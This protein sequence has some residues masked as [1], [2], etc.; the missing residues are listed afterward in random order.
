MNFGPGSISGPG[1]LNLGGRLN[2]TSG[3]IGGTGSMTIGS[4]G[5]L[6]VNAPA[7]FGSVTLSRPLFN[8]GVINLNSGTLQSG[9]TTIIN[10]IDGVLNIGPN[11]T[12][13]SFTGTS[14][15]PF[16]NY[17][18]IRLIGSDSTAA[19]LPQRFTS[20]GTIAA[21]SGLTQFNVGTWGQVSLLAGSV[22][23]GSSTIDIGR[24]V[25][26]QGDV[27][28]AGTNMLMGAAP[29][30]WSSA[31]VGPGSAR[32]TGVLTWTSGGFFGTLSGSTGPAGRLIVESGGRVEITNASLGRE[33][34]NFGIVNFNSGTMQ[35]GSSAFNNHIS[36]V[37]NVRSPTSFVGSAS[38]LLSN[39]G[40]MNLSAASISIS[41][42]LENFGVLNIDSTLLPEPI[43]LARF[44][45]GGV[46]NGQLNTG[47]QTV[48][49]QTGASGGALH[50]S[51]TT[52]VAAGVSASIERLRQGTLAI[53]SGARLTLAPDGGPAGTSIVRTLNLVSPSSRLDLADNHFVVDYVSGDNPYTSLRGAV[54]AAQIFSSSAD[55]HRRVGLA[56]N[57]A[58]NLPIFGGQLVDAS[59][60]LARLTWAGDSDLDGDVD[61]ADLGAL[62]THWQVAGDWT[63]GDFDYDDLVNVSDL[64]MLA[65]NWQASDP[66]RSSIALAAFG[67]PLVVPELSHPAALIALTMASHPR[68]FK[69]LARAPRTSRS[70]HRS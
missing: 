66:Q 10:E 36:G 67:L 56:D 45:N 60:I 17:G 49:L 7:S 65:T 43:L 55:T 11:A 30:G 57:A 24:A 63:A 4:A 3:T 2:W 58:L 27:T 42:P 23:C 44:T 59:S 61:A 54:A 9:T 53:Q 26:M 41:V 62:A 38:A 70:Y 31:W 22:I 15:L 50:G 18:T 16:T 69:R 19:V 34:D 6:D 5:V 8:S 47:S 39:S 68:L 35:L 52:T 21:V 25:V 12:I 33:A 28:L 48:T 14:G 46:I 20:A 13:A 37:V 64:G 51:G 29:S 40:K 32:I 1:H